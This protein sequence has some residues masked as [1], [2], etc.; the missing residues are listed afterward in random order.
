[1][2]LLSMRAGFADQGACRL[3]TKGAK[4]VCGSGGGVGGYAHG[5]FVCFGWCELQT[6]GGT[7]R[8]AWATAAIGQCVGG[9]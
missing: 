5:E 2:L 1:M 3:D 4:E 7:E 6:P 9:L 8:F